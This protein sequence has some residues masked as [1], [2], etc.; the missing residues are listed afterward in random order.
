ME[1]HLHFK[2]FG[3]RFQDFFFLWRGAVNNIRM[4]H[5]TIAHVYVYYVPV[6]N[7]FVYMYVFQCMVPTAVDI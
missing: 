5:R 4:N 6:R 7:I 1:M 3:I 2:K